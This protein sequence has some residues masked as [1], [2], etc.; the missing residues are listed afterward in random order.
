MSLS[1]EAQYIPGSQSASPSPLSRHLPPIPEGIVSSWIDSL[2]PPIPRNTW[3]L[4][5]FGASPRTVL[6]LASAGYRVLVAAN[7]P[8]SRFLIEMA[9][10]P[11]AEGEFHAAL[12]ELATA[13]KGDERIEPHIRALYATECSRCGRTIM[14]DSFLWERESVAP[15]AR[16]YT[17]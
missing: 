17:C 9:A 2:S 5:P 4:D 8:V 14:A 15:Y 13:R 3:I 10:H 6:E 11:P 16:I 1:K 12:A 7:N